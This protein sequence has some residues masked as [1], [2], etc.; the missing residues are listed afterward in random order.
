MPKTLNARLLLAFVFVVI[1]A[2]AVSAVG[3]L[4]LLRDR[5]ADAA[6][7][8]VGRL[9]EPIT[10]A[11][12][13][14]EQAGVPR[15]EIETAVGNYA[16]S[17]DVRVL[18]VDRDGEVIADTDQ[19]LIGESVTVFRE[20]G[21]DV[22]TRGSSQFRKA[23]YATDS[24]D[25]V[26][27]APPEESLKLPGSRL[28]DTQA[29]L[30][31]L[32][33][34]GAPPEVIENVLDGLRDAPSS[35]R[36]VPLPT[37]RPLVAVP[38]EELT[39]AWQDLVPQFAI[40][41]GIAVLASALAAALISNSVT[42]RLARVTRAAQEM[43]KGNYQQQL[44]VRGEDEVGRLAQAFNVMSRQVNQSHQTMRD[45]L[46]NVS[47][48]LKTPLTSIQGFSQALE[49]GDIASAEERQ[50][51]ARIINEET[52][53]MRRLVDDLIELS[54]LESGQVVM[55][56]EQIDLDGLL[57]GCAERFEWQLRDSGA[58]L[59][60]DLQPVPAIEGDGLRLEQVFSNLIDNAVRH[61][62][63][64]GAITVRSQANNGVV[65]VGVHNTG[66]YIAEDELPRVFERFFQ[67]DASRSRSREGVGLGLAIVTEVVQAH[68]G[69]I[70][71]ESDRAT[72][73]EFI[74]TLPVEHGAGRAT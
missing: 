15:T 29:T 72:G 66:S 28:L 8:R 37:I 21:I 11:V 20:P 48:E 42:G 16:R 51:A 50:Q 55:Q 24:D 26:L 43:A 34:A 36:T 30:Y 47:H 10:L 67:H 3:T 38:S 7:E 62:P 22:I 53:R 2:L 56:R 59:R 19:R 1:L 70:R 4:V 49:E 25:F 23:D 32:Y 44:D 9:A 40:A 5:E 35:A 69:T 41:G 17:F 61:T 33:A 65:N 73:T 68:K 31:A 27:F 63:A 58:D 64:G 52:Q 14:L 57:R 45:L 54:R 60:F 12:A 13:L 71:V 46:A 39:S 18:L 74:V 6:E